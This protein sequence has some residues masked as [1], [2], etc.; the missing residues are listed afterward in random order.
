MLGTVSLVIGILLGTIVLVVSRRRKPD[1][2]E[3]VQKPTVL[4]WWTLAFGLIAVAAFALAA[5]LEP[6]GIIQG[7]NLWLISIVFGFAA[8]SVCVGALKRRDRHWS[9][10]AGLVAGLAIAT[11]WIVFAAGYILGFGE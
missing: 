8:V 10:W 1:A 4:H 9:V 2:A 7:L 3:P 6:R 5:W 11:F